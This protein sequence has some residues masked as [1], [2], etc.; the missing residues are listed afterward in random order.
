MDWKLPDEEA[1]TIAGLVQHEART[2]PDQ[3]TAVNLQRVPFQVL[4]KAKNRITTLR[5]T[6]LTATGLQATAQPD[7]QRDAV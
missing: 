5:I 4:R 6:P 2:N 7:A 1:T 3:G